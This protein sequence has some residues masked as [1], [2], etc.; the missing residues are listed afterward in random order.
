MSRIAP[1]SIS[2]ASSRRLHAAQECPPERTET[3]HPRSAA[4]RTPAITSS[5]SAAS[6]TA[7][8]NRSGRLA[9]K[10]RPTRACSYPGSPRSISRPHRRPSRR[11]HPTTAAPP[12]TGMFAPLTWDASSEPR[13]KIAWATSSG[14]PHRPSGTRAAMLAAGPS[15]S[16][17]SGRGLRRLGHR[18]AD[19]VDP[20]AVRAALD[21]QLVG[22]GQHAALGGA[23]GVLRHEEGAARGGD[24]RDVHDRPAAGGDQVRPGRPGD[25][26]D[27]VELVPD[28]ERPVGEGELAD[29]AE[30]DRRRVVDQDVDAPGEVHRG[31][32]PTA[33]RPPR[34][35]GRPARSRPSARRRPGP[36]RP[37]PRTAAGAGRSPPRGRP[38]ARR[39]AP[40][41]A[42]SRRRC[43]R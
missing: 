23:V 16:C 18:R 5:S 32:R 34:R 29:R 36:A 27:D 10:T 1:R 13:N 26:E 12:S 37:S 42:R 38:P 30:P 11:R 22:Q 6:S 4:S 39:A 33:G 35:P 8:G 28:G 19:R 43:R 21:D 41:P 3:V 15:G 2:R 25:E 40:S 20:D 7:A 24:R 17:S 31:R 9:L 14:C